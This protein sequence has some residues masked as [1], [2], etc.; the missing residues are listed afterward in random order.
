MLAQPTNKNG[1]AGGT[2][3]IIH[4]FQ[5]TVFSLIATVIICTPAWADDTEIFF[6][7]ATT[8]TVRPNVLFILDTSGSM[9]GKDGGSIQRIDRMKNA[10]TNLLSSVQDVNVGLM[11]FTNPGGPII[12]PIRFVDEIADASVYSLDGSASSQVNG[13]ADDAYEGQNGTVFIAT[14]G[15]RTYSD[16]TTT[17]E[18]VIQHGDDDAEQKTSDNKVYLDSSDLEMMHDGSTE[19]IVG[20]RMRSLSIPQGTTIT[21]AYLEFEVDEEKSGDLTISI[22]GHDTDSAKTFESKK[23]NITDRSL[24]SAK[25]DWFITTSPSV[26]STMQTPDISSIVQE[27]VDRTGWVSQNDMA[28]IFKLKTRSGGATR[29]FE[30]HNGEN[31]KTRLYI[32]YSDGGSAGATTIGLRF[33]EMAIPAGATITSATLSTTASESHSGSASIEI[34]G[35]NAGHSE[36]FLS[37]ASDITNRVKTT[38]KV[39]WPISSSWTEGSSYTPPDLTN[40]IQEIVNHSDW[41]GNNSLSLLLD[42][43]SGERVITSFDKDYD[44]S[45]Q[46]NITY[47]ASSVSD[48]ACM[49]YAS[50]ALISDKYD[51]VEQKSNGDM[52]RTSSDLDLG[53]K[54]V[55]L[56]YNNLPLIKD[57]TINYAYLEF[58]AKESGSES[59]SLTIT[60][61]DTSNASSFS[62]SD[63]NL[64]S[65]TKTTASITWEP[66]VW[67]SGRV[68]KT[69]NIAPLI[70]EVISNTSWTSGNSIVFSIEG[71]GYRVANSYDNSILAPRLVYYADS[72]ELTALAGTVRQDLINSVQA[73]PASGYTPIVDTLYEAKRY[74]RGEDVYY[75]KTRGDGSNKQYKRVS[76]PSS[77]TGGTLNQPTGCSSSNLDSSACAEETITGSPQYISPVTHSCQQNHIVLLTDGEANSNHSESLIKDSLGISECVSSSSGEK[78]GIDLVEN[79]S[80]VDQIGATSGEQFIN[81]HVIGLEISTSWLQKLAEA[82]D[83]KFKLASSEEDL[84]EVFDSVISSFI[85][86]NSTFVEPSVTVN[87]FNRFAHR[88]DIYFSLFEPSDTKQWPG[89][90][91]KYKLK[92]NPAELY[93]NNTPQELAIDYNTNFFADTAKSFWSEDI[94]GGIAG[95]GGAASKLPS[96]RNMYTDITVGTTVINVAD[97]LINESNAGLTKSIL[98]IDAES[99]THRANLLRWTKGLDENDANRYQLGDPLH[100]VPELITYDGTSDPIS[101]Y[102]F[103][104]TNE[105]FLHAIDINTGEEKFAYIPEELL[106]NLNSFY[107]NDPADPDTSVRPYGL[108]G[109]ITVW[110]RDS[111]YNNIIEKN[112][113]EFARL[114]VGMRRGGS[115]YYALDVTDINNPELMWKIKGGV[116]TG[117]E[118]LGQTWSEPVKTKVNFD[119]TIYDVLIFAGGYDTDQDTVSTRTADDIGNAIYIINAETG[120][121]LWSG[122]NSNTYNETFSDMD[123]SIPSNINV[124]DI[125]RDGL[126]DQMYVGD[127]G[128]QIWRFDINNEATLL[129]KFVDGGVIADLSDGTEAGNRRFYYKPDVSLM[130]SGEGRYLSVAVGSGYRAHPLNTVIEDRFYQI[131]QFN[132]HEKPSTYTKLTELDLFNT[133]QNLINEGDSDQALLASEALSM[134][135]T[136]RKQGWFIE[137]ENIGEK[138]LASSATIL[139]QIAFTTYEPKAPDVVASCEPKQGTNRIYVVDLHGGSPVIDTNGDGTI[140]KSDR[141]T[142]LKTGSIAS[143]PTV[144]D[145]IDSKPTVWVGTERV[146]NINTD[147]ESIR[148]Y[149]IEESS[150]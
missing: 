109:G 91:K 148:T 60:A 104:G 146:D 136:N 77:Y 58:V 143:T 121:L 130:V 50:E 26:N 96:I 12:S 141:V 3:N 31:S 37:A 28:F 35:E 92:G 105:G 123:Y 87:Q 95:D 10:L 45:P 74:F 32:E 4:T 127:M 56:R 85:K 125:N 110:T 129:N 108:D 55:G 46:L 24:T 34:F 142:Q 6:G 52:D 145:T 116:T 97:N 13:K 131:R 33:N 1:L 65:R 106:P 7:G 44:S 84:L 21:N 61:H 36:Q 18:Q 124:L 17:L 43:T 73:L 63:N 119:G 100:S 139:N 23:W 57:A 54:S 133:T 112:N 9:T 70:N 90:I 89:N 113:G 49:Q 118:N 71:T 16:G 114:Y 53:G 79:M 40:V 62:T 42:V 27:I 93:D 88:D 22:Y 94:D 134:T 115:N 15:L 29:T 140:S 149:W 78:C 107:V 138:V 144:I 81:T 20:V 135:H 51:D 59:T 98:G 2:I 102:I 122:G 72:T 66:E 128:G 64:T 80:S 41:C 126:A 68:S 39:D 101:S 99:D 147:L 120:A 111:N 150:Q 19:Q 132:T 137:L 103:V 8:T 5:K 75:G 82:G 67:S 48:T 83:G 14:D 69:P 11:R 25:V 38:A 30:S 47:D 76:T 117:F 86:I